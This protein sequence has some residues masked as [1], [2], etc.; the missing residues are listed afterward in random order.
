MC[1][2]CWCSTMSKISGKRALR[3]AIAK[4][5]EPRDASLATITLVLRSPAHERTETQ[6]QML[7]KF[8]ARA[9][10][11]KRMDL[12]SEL[13]QLQCCRYLSATHYISGE[14]IVEQGE[15]SLHCSMNSV[16]SCAIAPYLTAVS[17]ARIVQVTVHS[18]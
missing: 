1:V 8:L 17:L 6:L 5:K 11:F 2:L 9:N 10:L 3:E 4:S 14:V 15:T 12:D 7:Q 13:Q 18:P 16:S